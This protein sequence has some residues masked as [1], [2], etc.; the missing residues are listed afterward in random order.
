MRCA[1]YPIVTILVVQQ[2]EQLVV[3]AKQSGNRLKYRVNY[4]LDEFGNFSKINEFETKLTVARGYGIRWNL[5]LQS[6]S[7][8][9]LVYGKEI[10]DIAKG[11]CRYWLYLQTNDMETVG[12]A[13]RTATCRSADGS[14][15]S[16]G[17]G[18]HVP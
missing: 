8:L 3:A 6:F 15:R 4:V 14:C 12:K 13:R 16:A 1:F 11:N 2:Y 18:S 10:A 5:F 7:Q 17:T 9:T